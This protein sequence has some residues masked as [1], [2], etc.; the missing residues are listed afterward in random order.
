MTG[1]SGLANPRGVSVTWGES[2]R[3]IGLN[4]PSVFKEVRLLYRAPERSERTTVVQFTDEE[5]QVLMSYRDDADGLAKSAPSRKD[6][7]CS[8]TIE[9][10]VEP[11]ASV[12]SRLKTWVKLFEVDSRVVGGELPIDFGARGVSFGLPGLNLTTKDL[13][14]RDSPL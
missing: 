14:I 2:L 6:L 11:G 5:Y 12:A 7:P 4:Y 9:A 10:D 1:A 13:D 3:R 8:L